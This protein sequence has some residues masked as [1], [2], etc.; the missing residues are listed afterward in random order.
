LEVLHEFLKRPNDIADLVKKFTSKE[1][2]LENKSQEEMTV[3]RHDQTLYVYTKTG[4]FLAQGL[5]I[6][7]CLAKIETRFPDR[8]FHGQLSKEQADSLGINIK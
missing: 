1:P 4:E 6:Q 2:K 3:E 8:K 7:E 5:T